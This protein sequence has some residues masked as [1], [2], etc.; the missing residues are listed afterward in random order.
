MEKVVK[1]KTHRS[2]Y[3]IREAMQYAISV[4]D[5]IEILERCPSNAKVVF[6]ND[7]GYTFGEISSNAIKLVEV[8]TYEEEKEREEREEREADLAE[9]ARNLKYITK[10][11]NDNEGEL[12]LDMSGIVLDTCCDDKEDNLMVTELTTKINGKLYGNT[13]WGLIDL[14]ETITDLDDWYTLVDIV[15][16]LE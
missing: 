11:V 2:N 12:I 4:S 1:F 13:N 8:E 16:D 15:G 5:L 7:N 6:D 3:D 10:R 14:E 9:I